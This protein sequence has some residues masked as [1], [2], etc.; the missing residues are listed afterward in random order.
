M[1]VT[2]HETSNYLKCIAS[3]CLSTPLIY[4]AEKS[5]GNEVDENSGYYRGPAEG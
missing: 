5:P 2:K 4:K 1:Y 3:Q